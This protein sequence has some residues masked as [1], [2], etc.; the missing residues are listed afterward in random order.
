[1]PT[2]AIVSGAAPGKLGGAIIDELCR[3][4][5]PC[6]GIARRR[7]EMPVPMMVVDLLHFEA[8][9]R[10]FA[11]LD[12]APYDHLLLVHAVG[13]FKFEPYK[14]TFEGAADP[15][16]IASNCDTLR[17]LY[18]GFEYRHDSPKMLAITHVCI[19]SLAEDYH[20]PCYHSFS[21][22]RMFIRSGWPTFVKNP[23]H[24]VL[25]IKTCTI[26]VPSEVALRPYADMTY[27]MDPHD[28]ARRVVPFM[29][30]M[31]RGLYIERDIYV[32]MPGFD[33]AP[34]YTDH[35]LILERW[36]HDMGEEAFDRLLEEGRSLE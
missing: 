7:V 22:A 27:W 4:N 12:L 20:I 23:K 13:K 32:D 29:L 3:K 28:F 30:S 15:S 14:T 34:Y 8:V 18:G 1:M 25:Y 16:V 26:K 24:A 19:G 33:P 6:I 35:K 5:I 9:R 31:P 17:N 21:C 11:E 36:R 2:L 10:K